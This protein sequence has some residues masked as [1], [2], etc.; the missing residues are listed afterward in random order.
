MT[1]QRHQRGWQPPAIHTVPGNKRAQNVRQVL[2][3]GTLKP[4]QN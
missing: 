3:S 4:Q 1:R 2:G